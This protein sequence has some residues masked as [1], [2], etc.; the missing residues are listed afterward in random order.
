MDFVVVFTSLVFQYSTLK[1]QEVKRGAY[2]SDQVC[3][4][5]LVCAVTRSCVAKRS[6]QNTM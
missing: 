1:C 4:G 2:F 5:W 3:P 6:V